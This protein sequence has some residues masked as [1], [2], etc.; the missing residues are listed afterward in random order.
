MSQDAPRLLIVSHNFAPDISIGARRVHRIATQMKARGWQVDVLCTRRVYQQG[1][2]PKLAVGL[3]GMKIIRTHALEPRAWARLVRDRVLGRLDARPTPKTAASPTDSDVSNSHFAGAPTKLAKQLIDGLRTVASGL[4][5]NYVEFPDEVGGWIPLALLNSV[6]FKRPDVV[7]ASMPWHSSA[8]IGAALAT[9]FD[10]GLV[11]DYRDPW[12]AAVRK[13]SLPAYRRRLETQLEGIC[14]QRADELV[15]VT[16]GLVKEIGGQCGRPFH[17]IP[18]AS[19]PEKF[20]GIEPREFKRPTIVYAG[21]LYGG[22]TVT[23]FLESLARLHRAGELD[24]HPIGLLVMGTDNAHV[25]REAADLGIADYVEVLPRQT[26][27]VAMAAALGAAANT[28]MVAPVHIR[29]VPAKVFEHIAAGRPILALSPAGADV[30]QVLGDHPAARCMRPTDG[31]AI[32]TALKDLASGA[33][34]GTAEIPSAYTV[35]TTMDNLNAVLHKAARF[36]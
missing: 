8:V 13:P 1:W 14:L 24:K 21:G 23:P 3:D 12:H 30:D 33:W 11:L 15:T 32:D 4:M 35:K 27:Q 7:I 17:L 31:A 6:R 34:Q 29:Q 28:L 18:N 36:G 19:E 2:N 20:A 9:R 26:H 5:V 16:A 10:S 25:V 22:R